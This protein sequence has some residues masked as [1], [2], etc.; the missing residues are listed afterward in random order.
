MFFPV[1]DLVPDPPN[2]SN[3]VIWPG[4]QLKEGVLVSNALGILNVKQDTTDLLLVRSLD[5]IQSQ[6]LVTIMGK[7]EFFPESEAP[8]ELGICVVLGRNLMEVKDGWKKERGRR[9]TKF[10]VMS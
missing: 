4:S 10:F 3:E 6:F 8:L 2:Q 9:K 7:V 5:L 1:H